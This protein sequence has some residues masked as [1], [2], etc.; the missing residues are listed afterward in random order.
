MFTNTDTTII[1]YDSK[2][3]TTH[4]AGTQK[5]K[6]NNLKMDSTKKILYL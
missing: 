1:F 2:I 6:N 3:T 4:L 5:L